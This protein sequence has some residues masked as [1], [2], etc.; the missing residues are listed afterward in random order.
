MSL[1]KELDIA[2]KL[3]REAGQVLLKYYQS[4][5]EVSYKDKAQSDPVTVADEE[6]N[7]LIVN[8]I[9]AAMPDDAI[10]AEESA[11]DTERHNKR[12]VWC[13]DPMDG[14]REFVQGNGQ[15]SVM[16]GLAID[17]EARLGV[18]FEPTTDTLISGIPGEAWIERDG[19]RKKV[20][21]TREDQPANATLMV[22]RSHPSKNVQRFAESLK[23]DKTMPMGSVGLKVLR[24]AEAVADVYL[25]TSNQTKEWDACAPE[26]I[27]RAAGGL[28][29]DLFGEPLRYNK[30][31]VAM[32]KGLLA[33]NGPLHDASLR[34]LEP[35]LKDKG[36]C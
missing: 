28:M 18:V 19:E 2:C 17:G 22:S 24:V 31:D 3:A 33:S 12:R 16:I 30:R 21:V 7:E 13:I 36:W 34:A 32:T 26:A 9:K 25:T 4:D 29:T 35:I 6:A 10:L 23:I 1:E 15:F 8:A 14:T 20:S 11:D 27:I 5:F